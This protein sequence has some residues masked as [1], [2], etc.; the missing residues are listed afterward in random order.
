MTRVVSLP[1]EKVPAPPSP[2]WTWLSGFRTP[3]LPEG[4]DVGETLRNRLPPFE[5]KNGH[6]LRGERQG[7][8][9][10]RR[11]AASNNRP[12]PWIEAS[13]PQ[14]GASRQGS[15]LLFIAPLIPACQAGLA[16]CASS[17][18]APRRSLRLFRNVRHLRHTHP[19]CFLSRTW[20]P[21]DAIRQPDDQQKDEAGRTGTPRIDRP[22]DHPE[23]GDRTLGKAEEGG[24][25]GGEKVLP[26]AEG[27]SQTVDIQ[28]H[29]LLSIEKCQPLL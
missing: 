7:S 9:K 17:R 22:P 6:P 3:P 1:S 8:E 26:L 27:E 11:S 5:Q 21:A 20:S 13:R 2:K 28:Y 16:G 25:A 18:N 29:C 12:S 24:D 15:R 4:A 14:G 10:P 23:F 19:R